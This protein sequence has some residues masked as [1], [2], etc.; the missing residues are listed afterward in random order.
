M[1]AP[2]PHQH[3]PQP[4]SAH[5]Q[6]ARYAGGLPTPTSSAPAHHGYSDHGSRTATLPPPRPSG[7]AQLP[8]LAESR[9]ST[10]ASINAAA[11]AAAAQLK[12]DDSLPA[13][14]DFVK[15]L[16]RMLEDPSFSNVV[17]WNPV[18]DAFVVRDMTEFTKTIL[19]RLFKHSNFASFV[20]QLNKYDFHKVKNPDDTY[21]EH[22]WTFQ[23]PDFRADRRDMLENIKRK[24]PAA[25]K[26]RPSTPTVAPSPPATNGTSAHGANGVHP[27]SPVAANVPSSS[28]ATP[29]N[30]SVIP[31]SVS[32]Q[33]AQHS[34]H[35]SQHSSAISILQNQVVELTR[36]LEG[37]Q[38]QISELTSLYQRNLD[39]LISVRQALAEQDS[40]VGGIM[41]YTVRNTTKV[42]PVVNGIGHPVQRYQNG[43]Y[44]VQM[45]GQMHAAVQQPI[46]QQQVMQQQQSA[47]TSPAHSPS[48]AR[49]RNASLMEAAQA[50]AAAQM[51]AQADAQAQ[52]VQAAQMAQI[53]EAQA[54]AHAQMQVQAAHARAQAQ[55]NAE[56]VA[57]AQA[58][59]AAHAHAQAQAEA[60]MQMKTDP[61]MAN[62]Y[63]GMPGSAQTS[64]THVNPQATLA[65][66][67][68]MQ[69]TG[70]PAEMPQM[71]QA[72]MPVPAA[73]ADPAY[74]INNLVPDPSTVAAMGALPLTPGSFSR[75]QAAVGMLPDL[76]DGLGNPSM[77]MVT[78]AD[79]FS[80]LGNTLGAPLSPGTMEALGFEMP[81][82]TLQDSNGAPVVSVGPILQTNSSSSSPPSKSPPGSASG[83]RPQASKVRRFSKS[84]SSIPVILWNQTPKVLVVD[85]DIV[86]RGL[87]KKWL[88][89]FGIDAAVAKDGAEAVRLAQT[90]EFNLMLMD[91]VMPVID[92]IGA[93]NMIRQFDRSTP[94]VPMTSNDS[95][96]N[97][98][99]YVSHGMTGILRKPFNRD[100]LLALL[101]THLHRLQARD[102]H[103][104]PDRP[105][106]PS[107]PLVQASITEIEDESDEED[108]E[109][110]KA[111]PLGDVKKNLSKEEFGRVLANLRGFGLDLTAGNPVN[112][113]ST[114]VMQTSVSQ[115]KRVLVDAEMPEAKRQRFQVMQ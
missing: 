86:S 15:K 105:P 28:T 81:M 17:S 54:Q 66:G 40:V 99:S 48:S 34:S 42:E 76:T 37:A 46:P 114:P 101:E 64:P 51:Q 103:F 47:H 44:A 36:N 109:Q 7:Q 55:A 61:G 6:S 79:L 87:S 31:A 4:H 5:P 24:V 73:N 74:G 35:I 82:F 62:A 95:P 10:S 18:G 70:M 57:V 83:P 25:K 29:P 80:S 68:Q 13:T 32:S 88:S 33:L 22:S 67:A 2:Y 41:G 65:A 8:P 98:A 85:D 111:T 56:A 71:E 27:A 49:A 9:A 43:Q 110:V 11:A 26:A 107:R 115:N 59:A 93:T 50:Q 63:A 1:G 77:Q 16:F 38:R 91:I 12:D 39:E 72:A 96:A 60:H 106:S 112:P 104:P 84:K 20:R 21:G 3:Y 94:I 108:T 14:S 53:A 69:M 75:M 52:S 30:G 89:K 23:H 100:S 92:G 102:V 90:R 19:P 113:D 45:N 97:L 58:Q 78:P